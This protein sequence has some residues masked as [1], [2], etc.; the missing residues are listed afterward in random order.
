MIKRLVGFFAR[1]YREPP[2][3]LKGVGLFAILHKLRKRL[4]GG[5][6]A[7]KLH[8]EGAFNPGGK[9]SGRFADAV[10]WTSIPGLA[11]QLETLTTGGQNKWRG[12]FPA[13]ALERWGSKLPHRGLRALVIDGGDAPTAVAW[14]QAIQAVSEIVVLGDAGDT[15]ATAVRRIA[16]E[17]VDKSGSWHLLVA[18]NAL[19]RLLDPAAGLAKLR[20]VMATGGIAVVRGYVG[21]NRYQLGQ[22]QMGVV[23]SLLAL[24]PD[25]WKRLE[26]GLILE[27][28]T[29]PPLTWLLENDPA[30]AVKAEDVRT[31]VK[32]T[33]A[34][35]EEAELGGTVLMPLL[36]GIGRAFLQGTPESVALIRH[37]RQ[38]ENALIA[39]GLLQSDHWFAV[40]LQAPARLDGNRDEGAFISKDKVL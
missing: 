12:N 5:A 39:A 18:D 25:A 22:E 29:P 2:G 40:A 30:A 13:Y 16:W 3:R 7:V 14:L 15:G 17:E 4:V 32:T 27:K 31:A 20:A 23:N 21:I 28:Q 34:V 26:G 11:E 35:C 8:G 37:L 33:F 24:L 1:L 6:A 38:V 10:F 19:S 9:K 36:A